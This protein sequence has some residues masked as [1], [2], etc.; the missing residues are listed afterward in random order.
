MKMIT[1]SSH[2]WKRTSRGVS[3]FRVFRRT[4]I[5]WPVI[6]A[7]IREQAARPA[8]VKAIMGSAQVPTTFDAMVIS[9]RFMI[10]TAYI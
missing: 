6:L 7:I 9:F 2:R 3:F 4:R 5:P 8:P 1:T 10:N